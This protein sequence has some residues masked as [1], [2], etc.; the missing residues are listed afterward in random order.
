MWYVWFTGL[1]ETLLVSYTTSRCTWALVDED[2]AQKLVSTTEPNAKQWLFT[3]MESLLTDQF[4]LLS[5]TLWAIWPVRRKAI[6]E[7][8]FHT[9]QATLSFIKNLLGSSIHSKKHNH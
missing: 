2:L 7:G 4:V 6:H 5:V 9:S 8:I 3:L 1:V